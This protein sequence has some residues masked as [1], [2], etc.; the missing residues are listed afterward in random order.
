MSDDVLDNSLVLYKHNMLIES[1][2]EF[3]ELQ[4]KIFDTLLLKFQQHDEIQESYKFTADEVRSLMGVA[5]NF[6]EFQAAIEGMD[7]KLRRWEGNKE[8]VIWLFHSLVF[9][10]DYH[11]VVVALHPDLKVLLYNKASNH[12]DYT[13]LKV[14]EIQK[15]RGEYTVKLYELLYRYRKEGV[16][17]FFIEDFRYILGIPDSYVFKELSRLLKKW[18]ESINSTTSLDVYEVKYVRAKRVVKKIGFMIRENEQLMLSFD[19]TIT[20]PVHNIFDKN[21]L[22]ITT[23]GMKRLSEYSAEAL[24]DAINKYKLKYKDGKFSGN[25]LA[26]IEECAKNYVGFKESQ[27]LSTGVAEDPFQEIARVRGVGLATLRQQ[28]GGLSLSRS[29]VGLR[30]SGSESDL[31][32]F[33]AMYGETAAALYG[34]VEWVCDRAT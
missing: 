31:E 10:H 12:S 4:V 34:A 15:Q 14:H 8:R 13:P 26:W 11:D 19:D 29:D 27:N 30:V 32:Y 33:R 3:S 17:W 5:Q 6:K 28:C 22:T 7:I 23:H 18:V 20:D 16:M 1:R 25:A 9:D 24:Q 21:G 2:S